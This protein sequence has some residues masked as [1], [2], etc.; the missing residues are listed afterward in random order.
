MTPTMEGAGTSTISTTTN[1]TITEET[2]VIT[3]TIT[4]IKNG[5]IMEAAHQEIWW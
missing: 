3:T 5:T 2:M 1:T 4:N